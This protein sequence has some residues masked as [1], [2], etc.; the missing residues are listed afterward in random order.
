V[1]L[2]E[3]SSRLAHA[4]VL[5]AVL[6]VSAYPHVPMRPH[7]QGGQA[8]V[9]DPLAVHDVP[10]TTLSRRVSDSKKMSTA[11]AQS[12]KKLYAPVLKRTG[13]S[14]SI[15]NAARPQTAFS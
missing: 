15:V 5:R 10:R 14:G 13:S 12:T 3:E 4:Y 9:E 11:F 6:D 1:S 7:T 8:L 2:I